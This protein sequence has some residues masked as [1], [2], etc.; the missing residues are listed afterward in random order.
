MYLGLGNEDKEM[1]ENGMNW[2]ELVR[3]LVWDGGIMLHCA[4]M[5][6][7]WDM[8]VLFKIAKSYLRG[9][10]PCIIVKSSKLI[11]KLRFQS[12]KAE[13]YLV[14]S[15]CNSI[16]I[17]ASFQCH[18]CIRCIDFWYSQLDHIWYKVRELSHTY[19]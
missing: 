14:G 18:P 15:R 11:S 3:I 4:W 12:I 10:S 17:L 6:V 13:L 1:L 8:L 16:N 5:W 9:A 2:M 19:T 7:V